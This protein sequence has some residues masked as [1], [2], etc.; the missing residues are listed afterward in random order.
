MYS[1][2]EE[3]DTFARSY[4][5]GRSVLLVP[6]VY[7]LT[8]INVI[9]DQTFQQIIN[10]SANADFIVKG[11]S[12]YAHSAT[13]N[14]SPNVATKFAIPV[15]MLLTDISSG[16]QFSDRALLM[17]NFAANGAGQRDFDFP[18]MIYGRGAV[19]VQLSTLA[20]SGFDID[21]ISIAL[22]GVSVRAWD[23][24]QNRPGNG[25]LARMM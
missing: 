4:Y 17:E 11:C 2:L 15:R 22:H 9:P 14:N 20:Y 7:P 12:Y 25:M 1:Q 18:R 23:D 5:R 8:F 10:I 19:Q 24:Y 3:L 6:Y 21:T 16:D 13:D